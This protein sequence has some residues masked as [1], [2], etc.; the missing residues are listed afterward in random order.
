MT[1]ECWAGDGCSSTCVTEPGYQC[2]GGSN[3][4]P[5]NCGPEAGDGRVVGTEACDDGNL[6]MI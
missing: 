3:G 6:V 2:S 1:D 5:D 4:T